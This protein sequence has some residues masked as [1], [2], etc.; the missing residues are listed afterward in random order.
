MSEALPATDLPL[1]DEAQKILALADENISYGAMCQQIA[2]IG[3][4]NGV[5]LDRHK[6]FCISSSG[7]LWPVYQLW[8]TARLYPDNII[9]S[10]L[11]K[12]VAAVPDERV[13]AEQ[14]ASRRWHAEKGTKCDDRD[15]GNR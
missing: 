10:T 13:A 1:D 9:W 8:I 12:L 2:E 6:I 5:T 14:E 7:E 11:E 3:T 15:P 4:K